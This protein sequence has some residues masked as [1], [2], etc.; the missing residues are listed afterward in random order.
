MVLIIEAQ[1][2]GLPSLEGP[3]VGFNSAR[4]KTQDARRN[5]EGESRKLSG[6]RKGEGGL[7]D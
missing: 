1:T 6:G 5:G 4:H 7:K 3:G 2:S